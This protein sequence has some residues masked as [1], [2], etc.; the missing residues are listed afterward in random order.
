MPLGGQFLPELEALQRLRG[1]TV[2]HVFPRL[3][4]LHIVRLAEGEKVAEAV[5]QVR[6]L[7][8]VAWA[9]PDWLVSAA[10]LF[11]NDPYFQNGTQWPLN[12]YGQNGGVADAD[13]D[14]P[15]GWDI[16]TAAS[17]VIVAVVDSGIRATHEDL[18][19]NLWRNPLDG[20]P[21]FNALSG[22][23]DPWDENG[24]GRTWRGSLPRWRT[25]SGAWPAWPGE[26]A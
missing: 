10:G 17:D 5:A 25:T 14:A 24:H 6:S 18:A 19:E 9:E 8:G 12:N 4:N 2:T 26:P 3:R 21:G 13:L 20:T 1:R 15:E 7:T 23:H 16:V 22:Q 11:P